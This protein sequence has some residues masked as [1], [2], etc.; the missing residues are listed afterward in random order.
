MTCA[1]GNN[2]KCG[3]RA[4]VAI[5]ADE[6]RGFELE[7]S[8]VRRAA[9]GC[10]FGIDAVLVYGITPQLEEALIVVLSLV[11]VVKFKAKPAHAAAR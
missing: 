11:V 9:E 2:G 6:G 4:A 5:G 3:W 7:A 8:I 1:E 10:R